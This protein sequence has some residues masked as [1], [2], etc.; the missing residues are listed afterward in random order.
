MIGKISRMLIMLL[1]VTALVSCGQGNVQPAAAPGVQ[2]TPSPS[3][4]EPDEEGIQVI[5]G[6]YIVSKGKEGWLVTAYAKRDG[7]PYVDAFW[8]SVNDHTRLLDADGISVGTDHFDIGS[9]VQVWS[10][11]LIEESYPSRTTASQIRMIEEQAADAPRLEIS[12]EEAS[13]AA[14]QWKSDEEQSAFRT[15]KHISLDESKSYWDVEL[16]QFENAGQWSHI[17]VDAVSGAVTAVS[18]AENDA[19]RLFAPKA[20]EEAG[21]SFTVE[22][23]ARVFEASFG[24]TLEDGH[25]ILA[26]GHAMADEGAPAWGKF[27]FE[28]NYRE[29]SQRHLLLFLYTESAKDGSKEHSIIVPLKAPE[30]LIRYD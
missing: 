22:G 15:I 16:V 26:E 30:E 8:F 2:A 17:R 14:L 28:V 29:A 24:W 4:D 23:E 13:K 21:T 12:E 18:V 20:G 25:N 5:D 7:T 27:R 1:F 19:L 10:T 11:G 9:H 3:P 6:G